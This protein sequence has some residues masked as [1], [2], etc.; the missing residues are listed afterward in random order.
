MYKNRTHCD[1][2]QGRYDITM[3]NAFY[4]LIKSSSLEQST[5]ALYGRGKHEARVS[6]NGHHLEWIKIMSSCK[7]VSRLINRSQILYPFKEIPFLN[8]QKWKGTRKKI[9]FV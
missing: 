2:I 1:G 4:S 7:T 3:I 8:G 6:N 5:V 9:L